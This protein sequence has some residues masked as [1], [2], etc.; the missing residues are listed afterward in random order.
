MFQPLINV[1]I[2]KVLHGLRWSGFTLRDVDDL[3]SNIKP[4]HRLWFREYHI[5]H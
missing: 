4:R 3:Y 5:A 2:Y 1:T